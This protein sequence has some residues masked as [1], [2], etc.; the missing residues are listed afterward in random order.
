MNAGMYGLPTGQ[1]MGG[2]KLASQLGRAPA[3]VGLDNVGAQAGALVSSVPLTAGV[4]TLVLNISG[5]GALRY[6][7]AHNNTNTAGTITVEVILDSVSVISRTTPSISTAGY[8]LVAVGLAGTG[9][10]SVW[11]FIP[12]DSS[13]QVFVTISGGASIGFAHITDIHQ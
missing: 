6:L 8:G 1:A 11:D 10:S 5:R 13:A 4:R 7:S 9:A 2:L 12:F 3:S